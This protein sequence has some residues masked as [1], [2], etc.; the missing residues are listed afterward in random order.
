MKVNVLFLYFI[1]VMI[2]TLLLF[3]F[4]ELIINK[5]VFQLSFGEQ[6]DDSMIARAYKMQEEYAYLQYLMVPVSLLFKVSATAT[7]IYVRCFFT[8]IKVQFFFLFRI[9][10]WAEFVFVAMEFFR[11]LHLH[12]H[13]ELLSLEYAQWYSPFSLLNLFEL[14]ELALWYVYPLKTCNVFELIYIL[15][16]AFLGCKFLK[17]PKAQSL[18]LLIL[19]Y[20]IGLV[21][22][23]VLVSFLTL[24]LL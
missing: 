17:W 9:A 11:Y 12:Q 4:R 16:L 8:N 2:Y 13:T 7:C 10:L 20:G 5:D 19:S 14:G 6:M 22:W 3:L 23:M 18:E 15:V 21:F 24:N 1:Q